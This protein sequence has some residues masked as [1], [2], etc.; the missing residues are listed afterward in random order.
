MVRPRGILACCALALALAL[1]LRGG[2]DAK[3]WPQPALPASGSDDIEILFTFDDGPHPTLTPKVLDLLAQR[4]IRAVFF[5][6]G[7]QVESKHKGMRAILDRIIDEGHIVANHTMRH[8]DLCRS[9]EAAAAAD[10]DG[11]REAIERATSISTD[12]FRAPFGVRCARLEAMLAARNLSH[13]HWDLDPQEWRHG[14]VDRT[15]GY[16]TGRLARA[17]GRKVLLLHDPKQV[18][19]RSLPKIFAWMDAENARRAKSRKREIKVLQA[20]ELAVE[21]LPPALVTWLAD[22]VAGARE[23]PKAIASVLP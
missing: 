6:V 21:R 20:P 4:K 8:T 1:C 14:S 9:P 15:V 2:A 22:A 10:L 7:R 19:V 11:G 18:T 13:L 23:L 16:V 17:S 3:S 12:W 5:L